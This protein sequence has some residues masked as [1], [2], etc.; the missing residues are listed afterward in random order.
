[1][2]LFFYITEL[3]KQ[4]PWHL[5]DILLSP[6]A[7][8][9]DLSCVAT[10]FPSPARPQLW[11]DA[12]LWLIESVGASAPEGYLAL[13]GKKIAA[14]SSTLA[15]AEVGSCQTCSHDRA[16]PEKQIRNDIPSMV[17]HP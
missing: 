1:M 9:S 3:L 8:S 17:E 6:Y 12:G 4:Q 16:T 10:G 14:P 15:E 2:P 11:E 7:A 5:S 13:A